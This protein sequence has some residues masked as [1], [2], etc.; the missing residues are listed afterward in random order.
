VSSEPGIFSFPRFPIETEITIIDLLGQRVAPLGDELLEEADLPPFSVSYHTARDTDGTTG[1]ALERRHFLSSRAETFSITTEPTGLLR[2]FPDQ[3]VEWESAVKDPYGTFTISVSRCIG[4]W[5]GFRIVS[6]NGR[7]AYGS[8]RISPSESPVFQWTYLGGKNPNRVE[9][10]TTISEAEKKAPPILRALNWQ[11]DDQEKPGDRWLPSGKIDTSGATL[12]PAVGMGVPKTI[13]PSDTPRYLNLWLS[14]PLIDDFSAMQLT[15]FEKD[16]ETLIKPPYSLAGG[17][18]T[19]ADPEYESTGWITASRCVGTMTSV[20]DEIVIKLRYSFGSWTYRDEIPADFNGGMALGNLASTT[21]PGQDI[22]GNS[23]I[24]VTYENHPESNDEQIDLVAIGKSGNRIG[25]S[26][27]GTFGGESGYTRRFK[28]EIPL[29]EVETFKIRRRPIREVIY[30]A[31]LVTFPVKS[32]AEQFVDLAIDQII[33]V[34]TAKDGSPINKKTEHALERFLQAHPEFPNDESIEHLSQKLTTARSEMTL[35]AKTKGLNFK[36]EQIDI[37]EF[38]EIK[39]RFITLQDLFGKHKVSALGKS[40]LAKSL[41]EPEP[42]EEDSP[43]RNDMK[44]VSAVEWLTGIDDGD[45]EQSYE[46]TSGIFFKPQVTKEQ[47]VEDLISARK[48]FGV[49]QG[50]RNI[51]KIQDLTSL[52]G[53]ADGNYRVI[54]FTSEFEKKKEAIETVTMT[55]EDD[56]WKVMGYFIR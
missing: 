49:F 5:F 37:S 35:I 1:Q 21:N 27:V 3:S 29:R 18:T 20:P 8:F 38:S 54:I 15:L 52:P 32:L 40:I 24:L 4:S 17:D 47:W 41:P 22:E 26:G 7:T 12:P 36:D 51:M 2:T 11:Y 9:N 44:A 55:K 16:G 39:D 50:K 30:K 46:P 34:K 19:P 31:K 33:T 13:P 48:L 6:A 56:K 14:H 45:Y 28:F 53:V 23:I 43:K 25:S 42:V 10:K